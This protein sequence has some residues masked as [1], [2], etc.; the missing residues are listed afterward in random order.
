M[1]EEAV[2]TRASWGHKIEESLSGSGQSLVR[3]GWR[4]TNKRHPQS[5]DRECHDKGIG[6]G[7]QSRDIGI[8]GCT[9]CWR[10]R[11]LPITSY[12]TVRIGNEVLTHNLL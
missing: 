2:P 9:G 6:I 5:V 1:S 4:S 11:V 8:F 12:Y 3:K 7:C 10:V